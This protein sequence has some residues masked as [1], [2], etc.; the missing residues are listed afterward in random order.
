MITNVAFHVPGEVVGKG[1]ARVGLGGG[2]A[3]RMFTPRKTAAYE[4]TIAL[5]ASSARYLVRSRACA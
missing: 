3:V 5:A 4:A 1:R 2:G